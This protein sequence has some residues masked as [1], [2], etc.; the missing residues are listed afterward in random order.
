MKGQLV[1]VG[2]AGAG[3]VAGALAS[4][5]VVPM[6]PVKTM[7]QAYLASSALQLAVGLM[8]QRMGGTAGRF[9]LGVATGGA[10]TLIT[11][12]FRRGGA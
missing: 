11:A 2:V 1:E 7:S 3:M 9:G 12:L 8:V 6:L 4:S 10:A 5:K